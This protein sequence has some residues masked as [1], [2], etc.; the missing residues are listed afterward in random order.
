[1]PASSIRKTKGTFGI[2]PRSQRDS[3]AE[4]V[5]ARAPSIRASS[6]VA[7]PDGAPASTSTPL[8]CQADATARSAVVLPVP[9]CP[10]TSVSRSGPSIASAASRW[11][12]FSSAGSHARTGR[13][14]SIAALTSP[15][16]ARCSVSFRSLLLPEGSG[17]IATLRFLPRPR[18]SATACLKARPAGLSGASRSGARMTSRP[19]GTG[20]AAKPET[21]NTAQ[22]SRPVA[23]QA[24]S[25]DS[26][27]SAMTSG[28]SASSPSRA[29]KRAGTPEIVPK[30]G[31]RTS[32]SSGVPSESI[33][34][35]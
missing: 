19:S 15:R 7:F 30:A 24:A 28:P 17:A 8:A 27:P 1:M 4:S 9:A 34:I 13:A 5:A 12:W 6:C 29:G 14:A 31:L 26:G 18:C 16:P 3:H 25:A 20:A 32:V 21:P 2:S 35:R 23:S 33:R 10:F 22:V 11:P